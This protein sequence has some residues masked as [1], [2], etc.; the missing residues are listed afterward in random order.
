MRGAQNRP[1]R[2]YRTPTSVAYDLT[3]N[4]PK[5]QA[6]LTR[7]ETLELVIVEVVE[8]EATQEREAGEK[9]TVI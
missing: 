7:I 1:D 5:I 4:G 2:D 3:L 8:E 9:M 6:D